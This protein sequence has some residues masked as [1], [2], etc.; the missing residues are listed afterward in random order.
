MF[1]KRD[2]VAE[3]DAFAPKDTSLSTFEGRGSDMRGKAGEKIRSWMHYYFFGK[4]SRR[5]LRA[6][7]G[8]EGKSSN[9]VP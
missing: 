1:R 3:L 8:K 4:D 5:R 6:R 2:T 9:A 7:K